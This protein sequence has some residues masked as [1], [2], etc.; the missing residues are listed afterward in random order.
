MDSITQGL[1]G[2]VVAQAGFRRTLGGRAAVAGALLGTVPDFDVVTGLFGPYA[3]WLYH[4][5]ITHSI[6]FGPGMGPLFGWALWRFFRWRARRR[7]GT[8][9]QAQVGPEELRAWIWL[10]ILALFMV[11]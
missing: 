3:N 6:F 5:G 8:G 2:A 7:G 1:L 9:M 4:R 11:L 10:S